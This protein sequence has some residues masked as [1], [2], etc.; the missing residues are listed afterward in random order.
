MQA[1]FV[2][3]FPRQ[4]EIVSQALL[5]VFVDGQSSSETVAEAL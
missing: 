2:R 5:R 4:F 3:N 1:R